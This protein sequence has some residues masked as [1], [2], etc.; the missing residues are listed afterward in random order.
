MCYYN[1]ESPSDLLSSYLLSIIVPCAMYLVWTDRHMFS[2]RTRSLEHRQPLDCPPDTST[3][4]E[5]VKLGD[6]RHRGQGGVCVHDLS[7]HVRATPLQYYWG[8]YRD[9]R[10]RGG[11]AYACAVLGWSPG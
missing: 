6:D 11:G 9:T 7:V 5:Q 1:L 10:E 2:A 4:D 8:S 3:D